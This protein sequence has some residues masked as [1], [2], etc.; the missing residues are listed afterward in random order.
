MALTVAGCSSSSKGNGETNQ[1]DA[2]TPTD[3]AACPTSTLYGRLGC[4]PGITKAVSAIATAELS[5]QDIASYFVYL[6][7]K[8]STGYTHPTAAQ[9][10]SCLVSFLSNA[11]GGPD[12]YPTT[13]PDGFQCRSMANSHADLYISG[14]SFDTFVMIAATTLSSAGVSSADLTTIGGALT[15]L[16][17]QIVNPLLADAGVETLTQGLKEADASDQ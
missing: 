10:E 12:P 11:V 14:G 16:K 15:A 2:A 8:D 7:E 9:V 5:N 4:E 17:P 13:T 1:P 6:G 3:A